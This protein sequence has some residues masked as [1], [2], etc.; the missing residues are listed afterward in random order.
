MVNIRSG[1]LLL[2]LLTAIGG[3]SSSMQVNYDYD[4]TTDFQ[5]YETYRWVERPQTPEGD[6]RTA[7]MNDP[8]I[9]QRVRQAVNAQLL[10]KGLRQE[11]DNPDLLVL[12]HLGLEDKVDVTDWG[13]SYDDNMRG[14]QDREIDAFEYKEGTLIVDLIDRSSEVLIWRG[15]ARDAVEEKNRAPEKGEKKIN[16]AVTKIFAAYPPGK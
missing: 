9:E 2:C 11:S 7:V 10:A 4:P 1:V 5:A 3:C 8:L 15:T 12:Y 13:Y 6:A 16:E 14:Y